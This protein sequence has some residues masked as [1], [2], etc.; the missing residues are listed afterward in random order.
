VVLARA[1]D[2]PEGEVLRAVVNGKAIA[3][4]NVGGTFYASDD[5]CNHGQASLS[6]GYLDGEEIECPLHGGRFNVRTGAPCAPPVTRPIKTY[7]VAL[8]D[9]LVVLADPAELDAS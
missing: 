2:L 1:D 7:R 8:R 6:E 4:Y 3:V 5:V 9:G